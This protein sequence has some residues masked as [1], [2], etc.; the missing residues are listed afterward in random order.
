MRCVVLSDSSSRILLVAKH[1]QEAHQQFVQLHRQQRDMVA[2]AIKLDRPAD[3]LETAPHRLR[4][5][6]YGVFRVANVLGEFLAVG[7]RQ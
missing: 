7:I 5:A 2:G 1:L 3:A 4:C 6:P